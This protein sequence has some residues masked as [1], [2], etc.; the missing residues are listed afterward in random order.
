MDFAKRSRSSAS[1]DMYPQDERLIELFKETVQ[2]YEVVPD[3]TIGRGAGKVPAP[4]I[5]DNKAALASF[6]R[7]LREENKKPMAPRLLNEPRS[8]ANDVDEYIAL[9][10]DHRDRLRSAMSHLRRLSPDGQVIQSAGT[11]PRL[12]GRQSANPHPDDA[13]IIDG[14]LKQELSKLGPRPTR[15]ESNPA[16]A[17]ASKQRRFSDWLQREARES[18]VS[19]ING[20]DQQQKSLKADLKDFSKATGQQG[21]RLDQ[22]RQY[23][24]AESQSTKL[25]PY[26][27]DASVIDGLAKEQVSKLGNDSTRQQRQAVAK[28]A[29][30]L[31]RFSDWLQKEG[32]GSIAS[33][34]NGSDQQQRSLKADH[35]EFD[36]TK[37]Q[38]AVSLERFRQYASDGTTTGI[39]SISRYHPYPDDARIIEGFA[40]EELMRLGSDATARQ[41]NVIGNIASAQR[42][43][44][45]W[46][47][48]EG[49][50]SIVNRINGSDQQKR[51]LKADFKTYTNAKG[52]S[53]VSLTRLGQYLQVVEANA[54]LGLSL[55]Q[56][57]GR[58]PAGS[59]TDSYDQSQLWRDADE[60]GGQGPAGWDRPRSGLSSHSDE[61][62]ASQVESYDQS[63]LWLDVDQAAGQGPAGWTSSWSS[64]E[65]D[66]AG[67][68]ESA[69]SQESYDQ[70]QLWQEVDQAGW[71]RPAGWTSSW[72]SQEVDHA[73]RGE[74]AA[75]HE[76]YDQS[77]LWQEVDQAGWQ[78]PAGWD[79]PWS[80]PSSQSDQD[81]GPTQPSASARSSDI[82]R[83]LESLVD[84]P[85]TPAELRDD[86]H[87]EP[88]LGTASDAQVGALNPQA[89]SHRSGRAL[90]AREWLGDVHIQ[91]DYELLAQEL[92][93]DNPDLAVRTRLVD[94]LVAH[95]HLRLGS[96]SV[97][98]RAF[99]RIVYDHNGNDTADFLF[100][101][102]N[103]ASATD[104][105]RRGTHWSLLLVDRRE[106]A[107]PVAYHYDS[108]RRHNDQPAALLAQRLGARVETVRMTQQRNGYDCG[109]FVLDGTRAL[110]RRLAQRR[111]PA[112]LHLDNLV[113]DRQALQNRLRG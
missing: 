57:S 104:P 40:N 8:L 90:G 30:E 31:R 71:Q 93:R 99:Q 97:V 45:D 91:G 42:G 66:H 79:R 77:Q 74:S 111:R 67:R 87:Y 43:F 107:R 36:K 60:A 44:S 68:G 64:Q 25:H 15:K 110:V 46:L 5:K 54:A 24:G 48:K 20:T 82:Y 101:P 33:R 69:A 112:M 102:V 6:A 95:Y 86:A 58:E 59:Q 50:G 32:R 22:I 18:I 29:W 61:R 109:V 4:T 81:M 39:Q 103:D 113:V 1:G 56:A 55:E 38:T 28:I 96:D 11:G 78:R 21:A 80:G 84:L 73:G 94:P 70:S 83:G 2:A 12:M 108:A 51:S 27:D 9:G 10:M 26:P 85:S 92:Q 16:S 23:L 19:R 98:L 37:A 17:M 65:V 75:S 62:A 72:S 63:R 35:K 14:L 88:F 7:W 100:L 52:Q 53:T 105:D 13:L 49:R 41:K 106:R 47:Q 89:S 76:S 3:G 34:I